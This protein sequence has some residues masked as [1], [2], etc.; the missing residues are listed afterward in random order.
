MRFL[1][2]LAL[3]LAAIASIAVLGAVVP[4]PLFAP[5]GQ[6]PA[7]RRILLIANPIHT[8][9]ALELDAGLVEA[10]PW[11]RETPPFSEPAARWMMFGWG[12]RAFYI[13]TPTWSELKPGP[14]FKAFTIDDAVMHVQATGEIDT[15]HPAVRQL[16]LDEAGYAR[17]IDYIN[18]SFVTGTDGRPIRIPGTS[19]GEHDAFFEAHGPFNAL[20]G[21][22]VWTAAALRAAGLR[23]GWWN[24][25]PQSLDVSLSLY[26]G[27]ALMSPLQP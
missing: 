8:D 14:L 25:L 7:V 27:S 24:P 3:V 23:T 21:C 4:R 13:E 16:Q 12:S 6:G 5:E 20:A 15:S 1:R 11:L 18:R 2:G 26:D 10:L 22:N 17:L 19:Y 9:I